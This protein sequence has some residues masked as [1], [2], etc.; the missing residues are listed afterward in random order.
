VLRRPNNPCL[1]FTFES[2]LHKNVLEQLKKISH[3]TAMPM[4]VYTRYVIVSK[5]YF[6]YMLITNCE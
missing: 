4:Y 2:L 3:A 1:L 6:E 5:A